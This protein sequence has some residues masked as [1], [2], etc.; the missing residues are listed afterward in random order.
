MIP[1]GTP[2]IGWGDLLAGLCDCALPADLGRTQA[3]AESAWAPAGGLA[4]LSV[5]SG[6][7]LLLQA[8]ALP[9][10]SEALAS[11]ITIP[12]MAKI[13]AHHGLVA[14]PIDLDL[15]TLA[16]DPAELE[17][18][19]TPQ[20]RL[21]LVAHLFGSRMPLAP[22]VEVARRHG[23]I[24]VEDGAQAYTGDAY[25]GHPVADVSMVSFGPIKTQTAL[26]GAL[27]RFRDPALLA[28]VR[29]MQEGYPLQQPASYARRLLLFSGLK[30]LARPLPLGLAVALLRRLGR[31]PDRALSGLARGF[32]GD[33]LIARIRRR[34]CAALLRML[35]RRITNPDHAGVARRVAYAERLFARLPHVERP[36]RRATDQTHWVL[37]I[38]GDRPAELARRLQAAGFDATRSASSLFVIPPPPGRPAA[39][40]AAAA[41]ART[42]YLPRYPAMGEARM[43]R[44]IAVLQA[45][46]AST[47]QIASGE[48]HC[49]W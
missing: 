36:G 14:V 29:A 1:R 21:I 6:F 42:L 3:A 32:P 30:L 49:R 10:G 48:D 43:Q 7:D 41:M 13:M 24:L 22:I 40:Q 46:H 2:D 11:A 27:L 16:I 9:P 23:L 25:R 31:D 37:P 34:P 17:R 39:A 44:L 15:A 45:E 12:D 20:T 35:V 5:R 26:G 8:L 33:D 19:I 28:R 4:C 38:L 18:A 47:E